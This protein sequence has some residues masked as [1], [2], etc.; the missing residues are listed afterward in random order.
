MVFHQQRESGGLSLWAQISVQSGPFLSMLDGSIV[1]VAVPRISSDF[2]ASL[3]TTSWTISAYLL[4][5]GVVLPASSW[6]AKKYGFR[7]VYLFTVISFGITSLGCAVAPNI[8]TLIAFRAL[9]GMAGAPLVP[10]ALSLIFTGT[11][12]YQIPLVLNLALFL[13]PALGPTV[14]GLL[15]IDV[16]WRA[17]FLINVPIVVVAVIGALRLPDRRFESASDHFDLA[18]LAMLMAGM[19]GLTY[20]ATEVSSASWTS[21]VAIG[22]LAGGMACIAGY[23]L[24]ARRVPVPVLSLSSLGNAAHRLALLCFTIG[25]VVLWAMIFLI[26]VYVQQAQGHSAVVAGLVLLPQGVVMGI[27]AP[28]GE[29]LVRSGRLRFSVTVGFLVLAATTAGLLAVDTRTA[30]LELSLIVGGRGIALALIIQPLIAGL[31]ADRDAAELADASTVF[32]VSQR[33]GGSLGVGVIAAFYQARL[34][35]GHALTDTTWLLVV[36]AL[37][38]V[39]PALGLPLRTAQASLASGNTGFSRSPQ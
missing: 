36:L 33:I 4:A 18:G 7:P 22:S 15:V 16:G 23:L 1:N 2:H 34:P 20:G 39:V 38:G 8:E 35:S 28:F 37:V 14:G 12:R 9:Q 31:L 25:S 32:T 30:P 5:L 11:N 29:L 19:V 27:A 26:P 10:L 13:A 24:W 21:P 3:D 17:I 6:L